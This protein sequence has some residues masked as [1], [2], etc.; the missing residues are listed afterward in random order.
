MARRTS[1]SGKSAPTPSRN[2]SKAAKRPAPPASST[3]STAAPEGRVAQMRAVWK[4]T[5]EQDSKLPL[6]VFGPA[7]VILAAFVVVGGLV[8]H[9]WIIFSALGVLLATI[10]GTSIFGRRATR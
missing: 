8:L 9:H 10:A 5:H 7:L 6:I 1:S 2:A 3:T 4:M